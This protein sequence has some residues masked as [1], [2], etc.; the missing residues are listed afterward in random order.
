MEEESWQANVD[1]LSARGD[2][3]E[4]LTTLYT[5]INKQ[6]SMS[7]GAIE[8]L[9]RSP[10]LYECAAVGDAAKEPMVNI[11]IDLIRTCLEQLQLDTSD[12]QLPNLLSQA[13]QHSNPALRALVLSLLLKALSRQTSGA[14]VLTL[15]N[16]G[17]ILHVLD[18]LL[19]PE[20][21]CS[22]TAI[23][24]LEIML[25][26]WPADLS[27]H[28]KL[29]KMCTENEVIRCRAYELGVVLAKRNSAALDN[30]EFI[31]NAALSELDNDD[32]LLQASVME[33][34]VPLAEQNHCLN[35]M[36]RMRIFDIISSRVERIDENPMDTLLIPSIMKFFSKVAAVQPQ[37]IITGYPRMV[38]SLFD[39]ILSEDV[40]CL[41]TAMDALANLASSVHGKT[42]L[43]LH[44]MPTMK[45]IMS[46]YSDFIKNLSAALK[47]RL[48]NSLDVIYA[49]ESPASAEISS[50]LKMWY[51]SFAGGQQVENIMEMLKTPFPD[52]QLAA[53]SLLKTLCGYVWGIQAVQHTAGAIEF[54][55]SRHADLHKDVKYLK[56]EIMQQLSVSSEFTAVETV[57]FTTY[58]NEGPYHVQSK[59]NIATEPQ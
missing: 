5:H 29:M 8:S 41:P 16:N 4:T 32:V 9:L 43:Q 57:R 55:L 51:E 20:S 22:T 3:M 21:Q 58:V 53:L 15:P 6:S 50:I 31:L 54:L 33:I 47:I 59:V 36:E 42:L 19:Q 39:L 24:I 45:K 13:L 49:Q 35:Y 2:R 12:A 11:S 38:A 14:N 10:A 48:L 1:K 23:Q 18:E 46:K 7:R 37:K 26:Q 34:L 25:G 40:D 17:L 52:L 28:L 30:V 56:W 27:V 44:H